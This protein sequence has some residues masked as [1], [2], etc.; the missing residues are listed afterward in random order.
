MIV[1]DITAYTRN[2]IF[3]VFRRLFIKVQTTTITTFPVLFSNLVLI[4]LPVVWVLCLFCLFC[5]VIFSCCCFCFSLLLSFLF[6]ILRLAFFLQP[7]FNLDLYASLDVSTKY[8]S[9]VFA[10]LLVFGATTGL[11]IIERNVCGF[12]RRMAIK[13]FLGLPC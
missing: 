3:I 1:L 4:F 2:P 8:L 10:R 9:E 6:C 11:C 7:V 5:L 13:N 12:E